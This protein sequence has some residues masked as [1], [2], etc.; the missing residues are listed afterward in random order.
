MVGD[1][2][3]FA[4]RWIHALTLPQT[5]QDWFTLAPNP[6]PDLHPP[7]EFFERRRVLDHM[8][9]ASKSVDSINASDSA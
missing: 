8:L 4:S 2:R 3:H 7:F 9:E 5:S 1:G 6:N